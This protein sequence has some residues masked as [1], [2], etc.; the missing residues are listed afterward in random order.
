MLGLERAD[1]LAGRGENWLAAGVDAPSIRM[2]AD[3]SARSPEHAL[4]LLRSAAVELDLTFATVQAA[5]SYYVQ[6]VLPDL[7]TPGSITG[8]KT[9]FDLSNGMTDQL[10]RRARRMLGL[11]F[12]HL[13]R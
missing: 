12:G 11:F 6:S 2:L 10:T 5:R 4:R 1:D 7:V 3:G 8:A 9:I 13:S